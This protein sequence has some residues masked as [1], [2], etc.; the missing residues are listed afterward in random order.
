[1]QY[2]GCLHPGREFRA[3]NTYDWLKLKILRQTEQNKPLGGYE[4][5]EQLW[6]IRSPKIPTL[7]WPRVFREFCMTKASG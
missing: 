6:P 7:V 1:M 4:R 5:L 2:L 3:A